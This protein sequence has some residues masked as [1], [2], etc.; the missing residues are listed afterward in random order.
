MTELRTEILINGTVDKIWA[1]L[2]D[3]DSYPKWNPFIRD[4]SGKAEV[5]ADLKV[6][7]KPEGGMG[8]KLAPTVVKLEENNVFAW[9]GKFGIRGIFDGQ[10]EFI[11]APNEDGGVLF[12]QREEFTGFL[13]PIL[14]P[15]LRKNTHRGF[16]DMNKALKT[17]VEG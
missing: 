10:H 14:W 9:K 11:L 7:I 4:I 3:F 5:G 17:L 6:Y 8:A 13:V 16:D 15:M 2:M 12:I 1:T